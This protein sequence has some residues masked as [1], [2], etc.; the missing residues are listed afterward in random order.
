VITSLPKTM[1]F[2][3]GCYS[4][5]FGVF[6]LSFWRMFRWKE[7]LAPLNAVNRAVM[8]VLNLHLAFMLFVMAYALFFYPHQLTGT[9]L[10]RFLLAALSIFW[11]LRVI[12]QIVFFGLKN[13][14]SVV[15]TLI[16][17]LGGAVYLVPIF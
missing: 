11:L 13:A 5:A 6:H 8:Q 12:N 1:L 15:F 2:V 17:L 16:F 10:G 4:A 9:E 7:T 3:G 14:R